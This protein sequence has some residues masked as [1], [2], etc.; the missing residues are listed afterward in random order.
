LNCGERAGEWFPSYGA[1]PGVHRTKP[2]RGQYAGKQWNIFKNCG[3]FYAVLNLVYEN[4]F[5]WEMRQIEYRDKQNHKVYL[6]RNELRDK[7]SSLE[8]SLKINE[9]EK[10]IDA[11]KKEINGS[12]ESNA[13]DRRTSFEETGYIPRW[14]RRKRISRETLD[15]PGLDGTDEFDVKIEI[16]RLLGEV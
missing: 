4:C 1:I 15:G 6:E 11:L 3:S 10:G 9:L 5:P 14:H 12:N 2:V 13:S 7:P 16:E 8:N